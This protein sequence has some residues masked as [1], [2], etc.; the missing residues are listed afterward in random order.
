[1]WF[2]TTKRQCKKFESSAYMEAKGGKPKCTSSL[3]TD[4]TD[5]YNLQPTPTP[6]HSTYRAG[7]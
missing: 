3:E 1:M 5:Y 2:N 6:L 7:H 4:S